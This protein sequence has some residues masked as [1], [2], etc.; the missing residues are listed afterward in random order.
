MKIN[1]NFIYSAVI[2]WKTIKESEFVFFNLYSS[3]IK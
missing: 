1:F 2:L 3:I